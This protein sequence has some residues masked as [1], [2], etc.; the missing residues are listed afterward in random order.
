MRLR[1]LVLVAAPS[2]ATSAWAQLEYGASSVASPTATTAVETSL[3]A[4][5]TSE[6]P[7]SLVTPAGLEASVGVGASLGMGDLDLGASVGVGA[8]LGAG[9]LDLGASLGLGV[10]LG[11]DD[12]HVHESVTTVTKTHIH[13][14]ITSTV[15]ETSTYTITGCGCTVRMPF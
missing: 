14:G 15:Y 13:G 11:S 9:D 6:T 4:S 3:E 1:S 2:L 10:S 8:S 7:A 5:L 12:E